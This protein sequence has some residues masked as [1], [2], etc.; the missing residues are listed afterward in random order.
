MFGIFTTPFQGSGKLLLI[1][2]ST[3]EKC[4]KYL[5]E[6]VGLVEESDPV[7]EN[8]D[9]Q[10]NKTGTCFPIGWEEE[11]AETEEEDEE[12]RKNSKVAKLLK[13][14][15]FGCG[16]PAGFVWIDEIREGEIITE[17]DLD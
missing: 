4:K 8:D 14:W 5:I 9:F 13:S 17:F 3:K 1:A 2:F 10:V 6:E 15:Y 16:S 11:E 12:R 7:D